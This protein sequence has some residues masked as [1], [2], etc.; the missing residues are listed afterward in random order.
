MIREGAV[1]H[2]LPGFVLVDSFW[3]WFLCSVGLI[4]EV[5]LFLLKFLGGEVLVS[6]QLVRSQEL[7]LVVDIDVTPQICKRGV[8]VLSVERACQV[9]FLQNRVVIGEILIEELQGGG[10]RGEGCRI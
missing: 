8:P 3:G 4:P 1:T 6:H 2:L 10:G 7:F 9:G 5:F